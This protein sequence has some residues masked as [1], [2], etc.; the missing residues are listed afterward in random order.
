MKKISKVLKQLSDL[1]EFN[2]R[3]EV[4]I[5][6]KEEAANKHSKISMP[7]RHTDQP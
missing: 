1:Y 4:Y 5:V 3:I 2:R 7:E 6:K